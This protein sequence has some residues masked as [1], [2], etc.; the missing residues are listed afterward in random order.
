MKVALP[1]KGLKTILLSLT[2]ISWV[3]L[4][5]YGMI[6]QYLLV[7][8]YKDIYQQLP[9][10]IKGGLLNIFLLITFFTI[11][12]VDVHKDDNEDF[13]FN[14]SYQKPTHNGMTQVIRHIIGNIK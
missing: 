3:F 14:Q 9:E 6:G 2:I 13:L 10:W 8:G 12:H 4:A 1:R 7:E 5:A 11:R